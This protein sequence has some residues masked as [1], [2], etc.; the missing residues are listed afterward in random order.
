MDDAF[1]L[2]QDFPDALI[3]LDHF[4]MPVDRTEDGIRNW[5]RAMAQLAL[6]P[7]V[8][9]KLS[10]LGLGHPNWT[11][12]DTLPL[13]RTTI[14]IFGLDRCMVGSNLPVDRLFAAPARIF[15]AYALLV[16]DL[17]QNERDALLQR[18]AERAYRI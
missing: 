7:N 16:A 12:E 13:L 9:V 11:N 3:I 17:S 6:A 1:R 10:G 14:D 18:N 15:E 4:G 5:R 8:M 2:A